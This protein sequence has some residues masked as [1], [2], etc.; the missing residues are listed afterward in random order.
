MVPNE[1]FLLGARAGFPAADGRFGPQ[2][3]KELFSDERT[4]LE[5]ND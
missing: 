2:W 1:T 4:L 3:L 5:R